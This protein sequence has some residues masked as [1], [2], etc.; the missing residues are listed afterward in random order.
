[1]R[2]SYLIGGILSI[3]L[4]WGISLFAVDKGDILG[5]WYNAEKTAVVKIYEE[6]DQSFSGQII[7]LKQ[8]LDKHGKPKTDPLNPDKSLQNRSRLGMKIMYGFIYKGDG[9]FEAGEIYDPKSGKTYGG[10]MTLTDKNRLD[11]RGHLLWLPLIG[12]T[13]EW[14]RKR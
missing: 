12:R 13:S 3:S 5:A 4:F 1:M 10:T 9:L 7:W 8:P 11:L 2:V 6:T 14:T